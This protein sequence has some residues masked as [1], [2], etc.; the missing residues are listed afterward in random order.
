MIPNFKDY[1]HQ[2]KI[3]IRNTQEKYAVPNATQIMTNLGNHIM[4]V[5]SKA[6]VK[7]TWFIPNHSLFFTNVGYVSYNPAIAPFEVAFYK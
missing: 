7:C 4:V 6:E 3:Y 1:K 2:N 5:T